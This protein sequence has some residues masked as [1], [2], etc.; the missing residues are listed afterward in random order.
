M[1]RGQPGDQIAGEAVE[2]GTR[3]GAD[4]DKDRDV[5]GKRRGDKGAKAAPI[6]LALAEFVDDDQIGGQ[7]LLRLGSDLF[8]RRNIQRAA[9]GQRA[10]VLGDKAFAHIR[11]QAQHH[12]GLVAACD[13]T[14]FL[15]STGQAQAIALQPLRQGKKQP[16]RGPASIECDCCQHGHCTCCLHV[17]TLG[18][19]AKKGTDMPQADQI[20]A[21]ILA[22]GRGT[23]MGGADKALL[24][25]DQGR[26]VDIVAARIGAQVARV[27]INANGA[28]ARFSPL[29]LPVLED[30]LPD[31]PGPLA[32]VLAGMEWA[33]RI[34]ATHLISVAVDTPYFP[35]DLARKLSAKGFA[36]ARSADDGRMHPTFGCWPAAMA[37]ALRTALINGERRV[38]Q[39]A[40]DKGAAVVDFPQAAAFHNINRPE[41]LAE[42]LGRPAQRPP[43]G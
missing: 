27:A 9:A 31:H 40:L 30:P 2:L 14:V 38:G 23:R 25:L 41:D 15:D 22:G 26:L 34:G 43:H 3:A 35:A 13:F 20:C 17:P 18:P 37:P 12:I 19:A 29:H 32:G 39:W 21:V 6:G 36:I 42:A 16:V 7:A 24:I 11:K 8:Q 33:D 4:G 28:P 5:L 1:A 10:K